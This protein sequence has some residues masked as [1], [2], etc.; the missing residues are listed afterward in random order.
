LAR[1]LLALALLGS[2]WGSAVR[3]ATVTDPDLNESSGIV[4]SHRYPGQYWTHNDSGDG[5]RVFLIDREGAV[6]AKIT[7][8]NA[9][10]VDWED[11]DAGPGPEK[12]VTYLYA[13]DTGDNGRDRAEIQVYRFPEP[14]PGSP[15]P[16]ADVL[17][18]HYPDG[19]HDAEALL[20]HPATGD[21]YIVTK[22]RGEDTRTTVYKSHEGGELRE[23]AS[24]H[25]PNEQALMLLIGRVTGGSIAPDG[26]HLILCDYQR[27]WEYTLPDDAKS[28]DEIWKTEPQPVDLDKRKQG[29]SVCYR[30]DGNAVLATSEGSPMPLIE[31]VRN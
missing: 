26:H 23:I 22:A 18:F 15:P 5:P 10:A 31:T 24:L 4:A 30:L 27:G 1:I 16:R 11:I 8:A 3:I 14:T 9:K 20:V 21:L 2:G 6:K 28:F 17:R 12:G 25:F 13:G 7:I 29:E 19:P